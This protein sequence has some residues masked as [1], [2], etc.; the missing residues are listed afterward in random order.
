M[1]RDGAA[2]VIRFGSRVQAFGR[3]GNDPMSFQKG[4]VGIGNQQDSART[5][6]DRRAPMPNLALAPRALERK[7]RD[8]IRAPCF[9]GLRPRA[10]QAGGRLRGAESRP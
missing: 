1:M 10:E 3:A 4:S 8:S 2:V 7:L 5:F 9:A 6:D